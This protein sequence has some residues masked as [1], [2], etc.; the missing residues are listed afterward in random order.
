MNI[1]KRKEDD[2]LAHNIAIAANFEFSP[3]EFYDRVEAELTARK[4]PGIS[5]SRVEYSEGGLLSYKRTYLRVIRE[6]LAFDACAAP[7]GTEFFFSYRSVY[8]PLRVQLWHLLVVFL[9]FGSIF[10]MLVRPLGLFFAGLAVLSLIFA[11]IQ[12][13][14]NAVAAALGDL[15]SFLMKIPGFGPIYE[16]WF[17]KDTYYRQDT[18][19]TYLEIIPRLVQKIMDEITAKDGVKL[20]NQ[21]ERAPILGDL[22]KRRPKTD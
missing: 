16:T 21:Y 19:L 4:I 22:Y 9:T 5:I 17:R 20:I 2:L 1:F 14:Q 7:F 10:L 15:D 3:Q 12:A 8:S 11:T 18:R 6:R 13:F